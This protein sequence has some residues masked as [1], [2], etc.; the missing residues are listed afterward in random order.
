MG[1][2]FVLIWAVAG[3]AS[4]LMKQPDAGRMILHQKR[5]GVRSFFLNG[6]EAAGKLEV[7]EKFFSEKP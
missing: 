4:L 6:F 3:G 5:I 1:D 2:L 7:I